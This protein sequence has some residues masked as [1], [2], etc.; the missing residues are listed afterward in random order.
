M[1]ISSIP[2]FKP[3]TIL[4]DDASL[5]YYS[6]EAM[7]SDNIDFLKK[8]ATSRHGNKN[9][10]IITQ[11]LK[12]TDVTFIYRASSIF[13]KSYALLQA[14]TER[15]KIHQQLKYFMP[16]SIDRVL[17][18]DNNVLSF[19]YPLEYSWWKEKYSKPYSPFKSNAQ[20]FRFIIKLLDDLDDEKISEQLSYKDYVLDPIKV[21]MIRMMAEK[22]GHNKMLSMPDDKLEEQIQLGWDETPLG[23]KPQRIKGNFQMS[24][25]EMDEWKREMG[26]NPELYTYSKMMINDRLNDDIIERIKRV[27]NVLLFIKGRTGT[28]KSWSALSLGNYISKVSKAPFDASNICFS[29]EEVMEKLKNLDKGSVLVLDEAGVRKVGPGSHRE[30]VEISGAEQTVRKKQISFIY[31]APVDIGSHLYDFVLEPFGIDYDKGIA[32]LM[33]YTIKER[34]MG[35]VTIRRPDQKLIDE[36]EKKKDIFI[37]KISKRESSSRVNLKEI[38]LKIRDDSM[39]QRASNTIEKRTAILDRNPHLSGSE[40]DMVLS[41][42]NLL[43]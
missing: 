19:S 43:D 32:R 36:Y 6:R 12:L 30:Q 15:I 28:G 31:N 4:I 20:A 38:A 39:F 11:H 10:I 5:S 22:I 7:A 40:V 1:N 27:R 21:A 13:F 24:P 29:T 16:S 26:I 35:Y 8:L 18:Y 37:E 2:A 34:P 23:E 3:V 9:Y 42:V 33:V 17:Y 41:Y 25:T 14:E